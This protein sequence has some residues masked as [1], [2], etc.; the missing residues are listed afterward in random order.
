MTA[1]NVTAGTP[2]TASNVTAGT[3]V[4][5]GVLLESLEVRAMTR[6]HLR[7]VLKIE[8]QVYHRPWSQAT[9]LGELKL[10][11]SRIYLAGFFR[12]RLEGYA[13][14]LFQGTDGHVATIAVD[15]AM[16]GNKI[17]ERLLYVLV[18]RALERGARDLTL[19]VR[20][21]NEPAISLYRK[22][23]FVPAGM[24]KNYYSD[25]NEDALIM[26]ANDVAEPAYG[27][28]LDQL[29]ATLEPSIFMSEFE[30]EGIDE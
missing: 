21:S 29:G 11:E 6:K 10:V 4:T 12:G 17:A 30:E 15:P 7:A 8:E 2:V 24:R 20:V 5:A 9:Y 22:F 28:R 18:R 25:I 14:L 26:W 16:Q 1:S 27:E 13:G 19:E 3:P 23:G